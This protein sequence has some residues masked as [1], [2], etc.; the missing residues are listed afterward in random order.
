MHSCTAKMQPQDV[1]QLLQTL[2]P[3][4]LSTFAWASLDFYAMIRLAAVSTPKPSLANWK[5]GC[6]FC[7]AGSLFMLVNK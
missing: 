6:K 1:A 4:H 7:C 3:E 5:S 2:G